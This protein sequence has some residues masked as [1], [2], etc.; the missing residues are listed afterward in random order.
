MNAKNIIL[1]LLAAAIVSA[2]PA[3][4]IAGGNAHP[5]R[6]PQPHHMSPCERPAM[7]CLN[8]EQIA[9]MKQL[10]KEHHEALTPLREQISQ[11]RM[12]LHAIAPNP[13]VKPD[14]LKAIVNDIMSLRKQMRTVNESFRTK[15]EKAGLPMFGAC[16]PRGGHMG[17]RAC[18]PHVMP[19]VCP[20]SR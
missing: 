3:A 2:A 5:E 4:A 8:T 15:I 13:N 17:Q 11:K 20:V 7:P 1:T 14:E 10:R 16:G 12:E 6:C 18:T 19:G 9:Q